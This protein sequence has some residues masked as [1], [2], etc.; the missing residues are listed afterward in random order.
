MDDEEKVANND[1]SRQDPDKIRGSTFNIRPWTR[2]YRKINKNEQ[3]LQR[4]KGNVTHRA[5]GDCQI[6]QKKDYDTKEAVV[7]RRKIFFGKCS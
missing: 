3:D 4:Q 2:T 1:L 5:S 7:T 6:N